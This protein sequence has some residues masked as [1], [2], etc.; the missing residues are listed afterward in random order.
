MKKEILICLVLIFG[1]LLVK[2]LRAQSNNLEKYFK[3][4]PNLKTDKG[5]PLFYQLTIE[6]KNRDYDGKLINH[7]IA[8]GK[9]TKDLDN[10]SWSDVTLTSISDNSRSEKKLIELE[11]LN[12]RITG[13]NFTKPDFYKDFPQTQV[14]LIHWFVQDQVAFDV[15]GLMYFDSLELNKPFYPEF[16]RNHKGI[17]EKYI[18]FNTQNLNITWTGI[19]KRNNEICALIH[20]QGLY[21]PIDADNDA[22]KLNGRSTFWGDIWVSLSDKQIEYATMN[23]DLI[24]KIHLKANNLDQRINLQRELKFEKIE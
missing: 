3:S 19:S 23:E 16:F 9:L 8:V 20:Y 14:E 10:N 6:W 1:L 11:G 17:I 2:D 12:Y 5:K 21:N 13:D 22:M 18:N 4:L 24:F 15:Y 7:N